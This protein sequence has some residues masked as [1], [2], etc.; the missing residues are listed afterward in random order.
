MNC[1]LYRYIFTKTRENYYGKSIK[2]KC[3][4]WLPFIRILSTSFPSPIFAPYTQN[5][6]RVKYIIHENKL[7][8]FIRT[9]LAQCG[10]IQQNR[11][12][13][14]PF[15]STHPPIGWQTIWKHLIIGEVACFCKRITWVAFC[16]FMWFRCMYI[17]VGIYVYIYSEMR[18]WWCDLQRASGV[19]VCLWLG[20]ASAR[21]YLVW[22]LGGPYKT[23][24]RIRNALERIEKK[25]T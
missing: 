20:R 19:I 21:G 1:K 17:R 11:S 23:A 13:S 4:W 18:W 10:A 16:L 15:S 9:M 25:L 14:S 12:S 24:V 6:H 8:H 7:R 2:R 3:L 5:P 22:E